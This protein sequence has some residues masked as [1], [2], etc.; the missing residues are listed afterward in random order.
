[1]RGS[2]ASYGDELKL[3]S[4]ALNDT[5]PW[6][7]QCNT[8]QDH[9]EKRKVGKPTV[10]RTSIGRTSHIMATNSNFVSALRIHSSEHA[11]CDGNHAESRTYT[12][13]GMWTVH[14]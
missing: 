11:G 9:L 6:I 4:S 8:N 14:Q 7:Q 2:S 5:N 3:V 13:D 12:H 10:E 1:M